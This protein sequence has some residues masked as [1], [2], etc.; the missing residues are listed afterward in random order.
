MLSA[1]VARLLSL[2]VVGHGLTYVRLADVSNEPQ[3]LH[4]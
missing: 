4:P 1:A 3:A 2:L